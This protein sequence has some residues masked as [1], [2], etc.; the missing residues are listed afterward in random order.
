MVEHE[1]EGKEVA[2]YGEF[3][4]ERLSGE[5]T[6]EFGKGYSK[7]NMELIRKFYLTYKIAK[8]PVSQSLTWM[9]CCCSLPWTSAN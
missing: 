1:Q 9:H 6:A 2:G 3:L 5:L 7:R 4:I 8:S